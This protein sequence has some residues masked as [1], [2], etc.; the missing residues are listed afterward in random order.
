MKEVTLTKENFEKE[1][2]RSD[3]T[4]LVDFWASWC[5]PCKMIAPTVAEIAEDY[6]DI[7]KVGKI[8]VDDEPELAALFKVESIPT[9][10]VFRN[11]R[12]DGVMIGFRPKSD[13]EKLIGE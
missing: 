9:L 4:V 6:A 5:G 11:G 13:I 3:K 2:L 8:N 12:P 7:V 1:V 10:M